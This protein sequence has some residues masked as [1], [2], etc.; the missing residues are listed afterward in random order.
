LTIVDVGNATHGTVTLNAN[1]T[2][3]YVPDADYFGE[4][5]FTYTVSD[6]AGGFNV[7][8][9]TLNI[10]AV[11]DAPRLQG[12]STA[13]DEDQIVHIS[14]ASLL[15]NDHDVDNA[16][17]DLSIT[18]VSNASHGTVAMVGGEI[19]FTPDLNYNGA[20]SFTYT[21]DDGAGGS[22]TTT[23]S[24]TIHSV[25]DA[26]VVNDELLLG[27]RDH[28]Y[29]LSQAAL[30]SNDTD[31]ETPANLT[32]VEI[33]N[34]QN[35]TATLNAD[36]SV[37][38]VPNPGFAGQGT[39]EYVVQD[40]DGGQSTGTS[41]ID[42]SAI[43][44]NPIAVDDS[45]A[46]YQDARTEITTAQL[47]ANDS[48]PDGTYATT[49]T[50]DQVG[51]A[52]N[53]TVSLDANGVVTFTPIPGF[54]GA[55]SFD[56]RVNDGEGG[57]TWATGFVTVQKANSAPVF[58]S[59]W[60]DD[61]N[62][63]NATTLPLE[64]VEGMIIPGTSHLVVDPTRHW[65]GFS[66]YDPDGDAITFKVNKLF[67]LDDGTQW[68]THG[69]I[70]LDTLIPDTTPDHLSGTQL[71]NGNY[72]I[73][74][75][76]SWQYVA[77]FGDGYDGLDY[78]QI[79]VTDSHGAFSTTILTTH[80]KGAAG[81][82][83]CFPVVVDTTGNGIEL[84]KPED[85]NMFADINKDGWRDQIGWAASTDA[86]LAYDANL[87]GQIDQANEVSFTGYLEGATTDL[88]GLAAFDTDGD[89]KLTSNDAQWSQF[90]LVQDANNNGIQ[91]EGEF[92][93]LDQQGIVSI[94]LHREGTPELN[95]GNVVFGTATVAYSDGHTTQAG[96]VMFAGKDIDLPDDVQALLQA[97]KDKAQALQEEQAAQAQLQAQQ[98]AMTQEAQ[99]ANTLAAQELAKAEAAAAAEAQAQA[100]R[101]AE[102][103]EE[104]RL[105]ELVAQKEAELAAELAAKEAAEKLAAEQL[106]AQQAK[107][108]A[109]ALAAQQAA[110]AL[111]AAEA[112]AKAAEEAALAQEAELRRQ[113]LLFNQMVNTAIEVQPSLGF[114]SSHDV[115]TGQITDPTHSVAA[116]S[117][118]I[119]PEP[120]LA[121][122]NR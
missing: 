81:G 49:L 70:K 41:Y 58:T 108:A 76:G 93:S 106:A 55:A 69:G 20:A 48:D 82:G 116:N 14:K 62:T 25:N 28:T 120:A 99:A 24:L 18:G 85:S 9:A 107:E 29:T 104:A 87:D 110:E 31:V 59:T 103:A 114:V 7:G 79:Q 6:G 23:V 11:N 118:Y 50:V 45:V 42:F 91:D 35:G 15:A 109:E 73:S 56:Y 12:E 112:A 75:P 78:F 27:K 26:P 111:A 38:F 102:K 44:I 68:D 13:T 117:D 72:A 16:D 34:V 94:D 5:Q 90:G 37:T 52:Q 30:L 121:V 101:E 86:V 21:V 98:L 46:G 88:E 65:G 22:S 60:G 122:V 115:L 1:G 53:G 97:E 92:V 19:V 32:I 113:A 57:T 36:H 84:L 33:K 100:K 119:T 77:N 67:Y 51:N 63:F 2:I 83:G 61:G 95:N 3:S 96:D 40:T 80:H 71:T 47:L 10:A 89:G 8:T 54:Y 4:A 66:A 74:S 105:A 43:N 17:S 39:F 64:D